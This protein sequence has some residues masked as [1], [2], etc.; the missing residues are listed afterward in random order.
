MRIMFIGPQRR[1]I[2]FDIDGRTVIYFDDL[3]RN[4][5]KIYPKDNTLINKMVSSNNQNIKVMAALI[6]DANKGSNLKEYEACKTEE[7][8][9]EMIRKDCK[10]KGLVEVNK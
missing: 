6:L 3:W 1:I 4:G 9:A 2:R 7:D 8:I 10:G 5:I